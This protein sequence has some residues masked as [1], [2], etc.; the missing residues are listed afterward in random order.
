MH[1]AFVP[2]VQVSRLAS[3][4]SLYKVAAGRADPLGTS[5][6]ELHLPRLLTLHNFLLP[7]AAALPFRCS[8]EAC[9][10]APYCTVMTWLHNGH[11]RARCVPQAYRDP[12]KMK[13]VDEDDWVRDV[14]TAYTGTVYSAL[15]NPHCSVISLSGSSNNTLYLFKTLTM[16]DSLQTLW[17]HALI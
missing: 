16:T 7:L 1:I 3:C 8:Y 9:N 15:I 10:L 2:S 12:M 5:L 13:I 17:V 4:T 14:T 11:N 6:C